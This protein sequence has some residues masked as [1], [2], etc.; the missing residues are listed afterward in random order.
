M[1][2]MLLLFMAPLEGLLLALCIPQLL[3]R[4]HSLLWLPS[5]SLLPAAQG[6]QARR[7]QH[8]PS[9]LCL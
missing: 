3:L 4:F 8:K 6:W 1:P 2:H 7:W 5:R 9:S